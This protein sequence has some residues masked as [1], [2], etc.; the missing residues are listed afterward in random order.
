MW[1]LGLENAV[2]STRRLFAQALIA[3]LSALRASAHRRLIG[4]SRKRSSLRRG[5]GPDRR[6]Q[7]GLAH[8]IAVHTGRRGP[9]LGDRPDDQGLAPTHVTG[10]EDTRDRGLEVIVAGHV[11][12]VGH[13]D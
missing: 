3:G 13:L 8:Q 11:S 12:A 5:G 1:L 6:R 2:A 10:N 4:S 9:A 7:C